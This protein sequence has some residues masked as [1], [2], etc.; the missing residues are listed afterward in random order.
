M[1]AIQ[2]QE[3]D[4]P[5][6]PRFSLVLGTYGR[7]AEVQRF[8]D[9]LVAQTFQS[10]ELIVVDQNDGDELE[11]LL[12][13]YRDK[14]SIIHL[15]A[16]RGLSRARNL[17]MG[18]ARGQIIAF[19]DDDCWYPADFLSSVSQRLSCESGWDGLSCLVTD[20]NGQYSAGG[21]TASQEMV[22]TRR[23]VWWCAVSPS[24]FLRSRIPRTIGGFDP[25]LGVGAG[26]CWGSAEESEYLLRASRCGFRILYTPSI[27][28]L[29]AQYS[30]AYD[31]TKIVSGYHYGLG[32][33]RVL[34]RHRYS[35]LHATYFAGLQ[36]IRSLMALLRGQGGRCF[37]H[38]AMACGRLVGWCRTVRG[39][40][41]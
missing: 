29:H 14:L 11:E 3:P 5:S 36:M 33:G 25:G 13:P 40:V 38:A 15:R 30:G 12:A 37:F 24:I 39:E 27:R 9:S 2:R 16:E 20:E 28:V 35:I 7:L 19:P 10:F 8:L 17:S 26:T 41:D 1:E 34:K 6:V 32:M 21:F 22:I 31:H 4:S 18:R 23:N